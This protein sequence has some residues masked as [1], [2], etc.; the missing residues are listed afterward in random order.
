MRRRR[1]RRRARWRLRS[2]LAEQSW[3]A[4][5]VPASPLR[6]SH[7][8]ARGASRHAPRPRHRLGD[9]A[10]PRRR[11]LRDCVTDGSAAT[12]ADRIDLVSVLEPELGHV[13]GLEHAEGGVTIGVGR[14]DVAIQS[15][16]RDS[17]A[18]CRDPD[19]RST[20]GRHTLRTRRSHGDH[21]AIQADAPIDSRRQIIE[22]T[23][24]T[25][26]HRRRAR[27]CAA[28]RRRVQRRRRGEGHA[29]DHHRCT[30]SATSATVTV[31]LIDAVLHQ[32]EASI[33]Q[34]V[35]AFRRRR[36][37]TATAKIAPLTPPAASSW[38]A[39]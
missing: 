13:L 4:A 39:L 14:R 1:R 38:S 17:T 8:D 15:S 36:L 11:G 28:P 33:N 21:R 34:L 27:R 24:R 25:G 31:Q 26:A 37:P 29:V 12:A 7:G 32:P 10:R 5:G 35:L 20:R 16:I 18:T 3:I 22:N 2:R 19:S 23:L 30:C 9:H 6:G